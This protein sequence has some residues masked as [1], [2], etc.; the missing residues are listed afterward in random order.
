MFLEF[1]IVLNHFCLRKAH[2]KCTVAK[3][4]GDFNM[5]SSKG[6]MTI[7]VNW[8]SHPVPAPS[9]YSLRCFGLNGP[10]SWWQHQPGTE[11]HPC[12]FFKR[13]PKTCCFSVAYSYCYHWLLLS[14]RYY[15]DIQSK[16]RPQTEEREKG[17]RRYRRNSETKRKSYK[18]SFFTTIREL[19]YFTWSFINEK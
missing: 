7:L 5:H 2:T 6:F 8:E 17:E 19:S 9:D 13:Q 11:K 15:E 16:T 14:G 10:C 3:L 1:I 12:L 4:K 18:N